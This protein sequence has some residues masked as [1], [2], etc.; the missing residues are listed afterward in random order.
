LTTLLIAA[1]SPGIAKVAVWIEMALARC[2]TSPISSFVAPG[3]GAR[4][5]WARTPGA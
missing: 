1:T 3:A 2:N 4:W 5:M